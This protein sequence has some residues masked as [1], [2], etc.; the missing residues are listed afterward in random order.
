MKVSASALEREKEMRNRV[1]SEP[2]VKTPS[3]PISV[4]DRSANELVCMGIEAR[5]KGELSKSAYYFM[6]AAEAGNST[7]RIYWGRLTVSFALIL[8]TDLHF[9]SRLK[10]W[11]GSRNS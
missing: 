8:S 2:I 4:T 6:K 3:A 9:R 7:G 1:V 5:G 11:L 10:I